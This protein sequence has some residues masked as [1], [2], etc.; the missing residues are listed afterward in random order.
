MENLAYCLIDQFRSWRRLRFSGITMTGALKWTSLLFP[1]QLQLLWQL[2]FATDQTRRLDQ[3]KYPA[4]ASTATP[5][6]PS[7]QSIPR[8]LPIS[9]T[10]FPPDIPGVPLNRRAQSYSRK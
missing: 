6:I 8:I 7:C 4:D 2:D 9:L 5:T 1:P 3:S 10:R